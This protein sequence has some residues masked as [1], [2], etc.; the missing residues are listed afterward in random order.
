MVTTPKM[1]HSKSARKPLT[2]DLDADAV[3]RVDEEKAAVA[4][5]GDVSG[6]PAAPDNATTETADTRG[7][8]NPTT[9]VEQDEPT[10]AMREPSSYRPDDDPPHHP[11]AATPTSTSPGSRGDGFSRIAAGVIG[12]VVALLIAAGLQYFGVLGS[13]GSGDTGSGA[14]AQIEQLRQQI[15]A[16]EVAPATGELG[17]RIDGLSSALDAVEADVAALK[18]NTGAPSA[19]GD[20]AGLQALDERVKAVEAALANAGQVEAG[21]PDTAA[22]TALAERLAAVEAISQGATDSAAQGGERLAQLEQALATLRGRVDSQAS[23]PKV[24]LAIATA[25]LQSAIERGAP[26]LA[27]IETLAALAPE[28]AQV[29]ELRA[30]AEQGVPSRA[31]LAQEAGPAA[32]AMVAAAEPVDPGAGFFDRLL[33][34]AE[35]LV[36]VRP[37]GAVSGTSVG[38]IVAR[39]EVAVEAGD[40]SA[41]VAEFDSLP[42]PVK[43][44]GGSFGERLKARQAVETLADQA[45]AAA[46][47]A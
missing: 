8:A 1:R 24:A 32:D 20:G 47:K 42:D 3:S 23:H 46:M 27:E 21:A 22:L 35:S 41:A 28:V 2:I 30:Y 19:G 4:P 29:T 31:A 44:A 11:A 33:H 25:A 10:A 45:V 6:T 13:P 39:M 9:H 16:I 36:T 7:E 17:T 5:E 14:Q 18:E 34:S 40:L 43:Q 38:A 12:A 26:F 37:I 15:A